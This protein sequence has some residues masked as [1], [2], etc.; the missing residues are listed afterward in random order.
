MIKRAFKH[1]IIGA[2]V[3][4]LTSAYQLLQQGET[5]FLV[6]EGRHRIGGRIFTENDIDLGATWFQGYHEN[7]IR[8]MKE[9][10]IQKFNQYSEGRNILVYNS[11][12]PAH[13]FE[14]D[15]TQSSAFRMAGGSNLLIKALANSIKDKIVLDTTVSSII[16]QPNHVKIVAG[17][18]E[19]LS[20]N[21]IVTLPPKLAVQ[22]EYSPRLPKEL[23]EVMDKTHT[24]MSNAIKVCI[25]FNT[26]FWRA[27]DLSGTI[28]GQIGP[29]TELYDHTNSNQTVFSLMGFV[30]EGLRDVSHEDR[31]ETILLYLQK[32]LGNEIRNY[33]GYVEKDWSQDK[34]TNCQ[35]IKSTY[36]LPQYGNQMF[37]AFY[38][39]DKLLF[40][41]TETSPVYGGYLEGAIYSGIRAAKYVVNS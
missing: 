22:L 13:Y 37:D 10:N 34:F 11:M 24:W 16:E 18:Q 39:N 38:M 15:Q 1:I 14:T 28:I 7:L 25:S 20:K 31:K 17:K 23:T 29:V 41:G 8:F 12:A 4:G 40:S 5:D 19:F 21:V 9:L 33:I 36:M 2:G 32:Y 35:T 26:P 27:H 30:N 3:S 6:L